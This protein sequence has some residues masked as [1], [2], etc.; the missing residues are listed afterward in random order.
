MAKGPK[1]GWDNL[2]SEKLVG[3]SCVSIR[4]RTRVAHEIYHTCANHC[5]VLPSAPAEVKCSS[6]APQCLWLE[7]QGASPRHRAGSDSTSGLSERREMLRASCR[8][9]GAPDK[10]PCEWLQCRCHWH[11]V[12]VDLAITAG[13]LA[14]YPEWQ[15]DSIPCCCVPFGLE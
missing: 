13:A 1:G 10:Q 2:C 14:T 3:K 4:T 12:A 7:A 5:E 15:L 8:G 6:R 11:A 9:A